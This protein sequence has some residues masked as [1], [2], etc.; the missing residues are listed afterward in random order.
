MLGKLFLMFFLI[1]IFIFVV[2]KLFKVCLIN[3]KL[4]L[5]F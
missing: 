4:E 5:I 3:S 1:L 2:V